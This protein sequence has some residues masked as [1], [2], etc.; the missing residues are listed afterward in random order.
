[1]D[2]F[3]GKQVG[4]P[5]MTDFEHDRRQLVLRFPYP[6]RQRQSLLPF[7]QKKISQNKN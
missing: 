3:Y 5:M 1:M 6:D 2:R 4:C 7:I